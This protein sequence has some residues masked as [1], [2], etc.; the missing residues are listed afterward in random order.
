[1]SVPLD[2]L[3]RSA[4]G[5]PT[6][7]RYLHCADIALKR[8]ALNYTLVKLAHA[9]AGIAATGPLLFAPWLSARLK[10]CTPATQTLLLSGLE[11]TDTCYNVS[12]WLVML[13]GFALF[14]LSSW[15]AAL[16]GWFVLSVAIFVVE[17]VI[18]KRVREPAGVALAKLQPGTSGWHTQAARLHNAVVAQSL[19]TCLILLVMLLHSHLSIGWLE[20]AI[21]R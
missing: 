10:A 13:T 20:R 8:T 15:H 2:A 3:S 18:E 21:V 9:L 1:M 17:S 19:C 16:Q 11:R 5:G 12:G 7:R 4:L 14:W 6:L